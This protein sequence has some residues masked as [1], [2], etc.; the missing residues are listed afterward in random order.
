MLGIPVDPRVI[1]KAKECV[2]AC[3]NADGGFC[4]IAESR[5]GRFGFSHAPLQVCAYFTIW[6]NTEAPEV[7][8][9][10]SVYAE[11]PVPLHLRSSTGGMYGYYYAAQAMFQ[12]GG[13][14]WN[15]WYSEL[16][17]LVDG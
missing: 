2:K 10:S 14:Q 15:L 1:E 5:G 13:D 8:K 7:K 16:L 6:E 9:G 3:A 12:V 4:Y 11:I 17:Q